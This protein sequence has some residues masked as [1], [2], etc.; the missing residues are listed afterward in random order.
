MHNGRDAVTTLV[1]QL[2]DFVP[3]FVVPVWLVWADRKAR[4]GLREI[5]EKRKIMIQ[6]LYI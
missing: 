1:A 3:I 2:Y 4:V 5:I 6:V